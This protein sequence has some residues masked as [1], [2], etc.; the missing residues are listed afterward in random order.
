MKSSV[1]LPFLILLAFTSA[2]LFSSCDKAK[3]AATEFVNVLSANVNGIAFNNAHT[4]NAAR[5]TMTNG[6]YQLTITSTSTTGQ[7]ITIAVNNYTGAAGTFTVNGTSAIGAYN[8][9]IAGSA[10]LIGNSGQVII[11]SVDSNTAPNASIIYGTFSFTT[12][13]GYSI[14]A[15]TFGVVVVK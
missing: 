2:G 12:N 9:G 1:R 11:T 10:D 4:T 6:T 5:N 3:E 14:T 13:G 7:M 8:T 15:G